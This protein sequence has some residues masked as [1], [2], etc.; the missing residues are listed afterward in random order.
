MY[1]R[2]TKKF[3]LSRHIQYGEIDLLVP[4]VQFISAFFPKC[5]TIELSLVIVENEIAQVSRFYYDF[6]FLFQTMQELVEKIMSDYETFTKAKNLLSA[7]PFEFDLSVSASHDTSMTYFKTNV[8]FF[9][10]YLILRFF[11]TDGLI[12]PSK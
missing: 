6:I 7:L 12:A 2:K 1:I 4:F 5:E 10:T 9:S 3:K 8:S 11:R